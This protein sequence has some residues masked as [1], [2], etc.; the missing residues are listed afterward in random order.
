MI[1]AHRLKER[2]KELGMTQLELAKK[3]RVYG[4]S[5]GHYEA[6]RCEPTLDRAK[7]LAQALG[8][9]LDYLAGLTN[10]K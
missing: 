1:F 7:C 4:N 5:I 10:E 8:V 9:S 2:R 6:G 3:S